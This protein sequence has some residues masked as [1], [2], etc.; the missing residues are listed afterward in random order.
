MIDEWYLIGGV[1]VVLGS[2]LK[3]ITTMNGLTSKF[4][5]PINALNVVIQELKDCIKE[6]NKDNAL[7]NKR[8][9]K[10][11]EEIDRLGRKVEKLETKMGMYHKEG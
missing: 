6:I 2:L 1:V 4:T 7:Q 9:E 8:L 3:F 11:G 10:H 5:E